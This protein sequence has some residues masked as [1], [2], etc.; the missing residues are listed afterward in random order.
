M[1]KF[2]VRI[3]TAVITFSIGVAIA[4]AWV[5]NRTE[6]PGIAPV[7]LRSDG[8]TMEMVFVLDTTGSMGGLLTGAKQRI[9]GIVNEVMQTSSVSSVKVGL[10]AY[11]DHGDQYITQVLPLTEDLD[12][13]YTTLMDYRPAGG[14]D[15]A[16]NVRRALAE[17][18]GKAG[19]SQPSSNRVQILFLVGDA[20]P[21]DYADEPDTLTTADLAVK[22]GIIV[23]TIQC[24]TSSSTKQAWE[25]IARRGQGQYFLIP[26]NGGVET[27]STPYDDQLSQLG[28]RL[29]GT[30]IAYGGGAGAEGEDYRVLRKEIAASTELAIATRSAPSA[31][32][33][34]SVNKALNSKAYIGDLLQDIENG[35]TKLAS[36]KV[37]D[38]PSELKDLSP[39]ERT[40]EIERRLAER[41]EIRKQIISLSKQRT[42]Y[43]ARE[44]KKRNGGAQNGFD[45]AVSAALREQLAKKGLR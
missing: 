39:E 9:W 13:V 4:T 10:V 36:I 21:H 2:T 29:G 14:G 34:R 19:W 35:S 37:E 3:L 18:V 25:A 45:V 40:K 8:Q 1:S 20:P 30:Y 44:Q 24:G 27:I 6:E 43:I 11:R 32:A 22:K 5:F 28:T 12:K 26:Q 15:E 42:E 17:G 16:E 41:S 38:L 23:N 31:A 33:D 7:E